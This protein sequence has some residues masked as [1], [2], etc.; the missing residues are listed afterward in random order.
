MVMKPVL[1]TFLPTDS[2]LRVEIQ[3]V[4]AEVLSLLLFWPIEHDTYNTGK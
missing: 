2:G 3:I 4:A 1:A